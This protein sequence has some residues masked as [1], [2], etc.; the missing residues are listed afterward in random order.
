MNDKNPLTH[1]YLWLS[2]LTLLTLY[3]I[4][5]NSILVNRVD[6]TYDDLRAINGHAQQLDQKINATDARVDNQ[7]HHLDDLDS[8]VKILFYNH[9]YRDCSDRCKISDRDCPADYCDL[10][11]KA[12]P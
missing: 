4:T 9:C 2:V 3:T 10:H 12:D 8:K 5:I 1:A 6:T 7:S 11:C